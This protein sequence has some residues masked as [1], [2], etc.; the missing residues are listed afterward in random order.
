MSVICVQLS[1]HRF[2]YTPL[3]NFGKPSFGLREWTVNGEK[4]IFFSISL[5]SL[6]QRNADP[7]FVYV[8]KGIY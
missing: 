7:L 8:N 2:T 4:K 3:G 5:F 6:T 1:N